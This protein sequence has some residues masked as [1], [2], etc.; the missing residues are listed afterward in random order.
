MKMYDLVMVEKAKAYILGQGVR[1]KRVG[2]IIS[3]EIENLSFEVA[4]IDDRCIEADVIASIKIE[5]LVLV[6][7]GFANDNILLRALERK[8]GKTWCKVE[9]GFIKNLVGDT[10]NKVAYDYES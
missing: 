7:E 6:E 5:D 10:K 9:N 3:P 2:K 1:T 4:F 8:G